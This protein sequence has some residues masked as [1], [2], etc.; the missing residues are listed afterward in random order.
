LWLRQPPAGVHRLSAFTA[1]GIR[2]A[3]DAGPPG[4]GSTFKKNDKKVPKKVP[5]R[6]PSPAKS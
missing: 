2:T 6:A 3:A 1:V 4:W 5:K